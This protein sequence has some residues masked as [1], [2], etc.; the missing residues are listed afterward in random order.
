MTNNKEKTA[1]ISRG[2]EKIVSMVRHA[3]DKH[4]SSQIYNY[5]SF[6]NYINFMVKSAKCAPIVLMVR[7]SP[8][9]RESSQISGFDS[10]SGRTLFTFN[11]KIN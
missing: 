2:N 6:S 7:R 4:E 1:M 5:Y 3:F 10:Q 8:D 9:K 11:S